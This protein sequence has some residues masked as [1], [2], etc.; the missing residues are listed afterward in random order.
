MKFTLV[1]LIL[2][3]FPNIAY[4]QSSKTSLPSGSKSIKSLVNRKDT[5]RTSSE[6]SVNTLSPEVIFVELSSNLQEFGYTRVHV[7]ENSLFHGVE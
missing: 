7:N 3:L 1:V 6:N 2:F 5:L 4:N